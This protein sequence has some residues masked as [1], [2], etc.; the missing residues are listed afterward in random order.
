MK[1]TTN[2]PSLVQRAANLNFQDHNGAVVRAL[3]PDIQSDAL[4]PSPTDH[5]AWAEVSLRT[6]FTP[7]KAALFGYAAYARASDHKILACGAGLVGVSVGLIGDAL[8]AIP[9]T[10]HALMKLGTA[11]V[12][13]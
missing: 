7:D 5:M 10:L 4:P 6:A 2:V 13:E 1:S 3:I 8:E 9:Y 12:S 11:G